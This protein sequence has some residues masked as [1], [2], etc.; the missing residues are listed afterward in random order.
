MNRYLFVNACY[1]RN[2]GEIER[3]KS[4][5]FPKLIRRMVALCYMK[6]N[7][8]YKYLLSLLPET[9]SMNV[10][11]HKDK[12]FLGDG[13]LVEHVFIA[14]DPTLEFEENFR[15]SNITYNERLYFIPFKICLMQNN[16]SKFFYLLFEAIYSATY[17][18]ERL[19]QWKNMLQY[20]LQNSCSFNL[21]MFIFSNAYFKDEDVL[22]ISQCKN[23]KIIKWL[24]KNSIEIIDKNCIENY[25]DTNHVE[26][27]YQLLDSPDKAL[28]TYFSQFPEE[29]IDTTY[30]QHI[31][32]WR[33][34]KG[35]YH[36]DIG[37]VLKNKNGEITMENIYSG[38]A[39]ENLITGRKEFWKNGLRVPAEYTLIYNK[40]SYI[41][42]AAPSVFDIDRTEWWEH[43]VLTRQNSING[44]PRPA[45]IYKK[46]NIEI[47]EYWTNGVKKDE[48]EILP[49]TTIDS[50]VDVNNFLFG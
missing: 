8:T 21:F 43:G 44:L 49:T 35:Q 38:F 50:A 17:R 40:N 47:H 5:V 9:D 7:E 12:K 28:T 4:F 33:N 36:N 19:P 24:N 14:F 32:E 48:K 31:R 6:N 39:V 22:K 42:D 13:N 3:L 23:S 11:F 45:I 34:D 25:K 20:V 46:E 18:H 16:V 26:I 37:L 41:K 30:I 1:D 29:Y 2:R 27:M 15:A 10:L